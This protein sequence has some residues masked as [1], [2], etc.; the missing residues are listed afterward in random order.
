[1]SIPAPPELER[2][3]NRLRFDLRAFQSVSG[4]GPLGVGAVSPLIVALS[5]IRI[6]HIM[7][8]SLAAPIP[9]RG[10]KTVC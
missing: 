6:R 7:E 8:Y 5:L 9:G 4:L 1:M 10:F 3:G 2:T